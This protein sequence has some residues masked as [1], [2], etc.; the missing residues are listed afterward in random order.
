MASIILVADIDGPPGKIGRFSFSSEEDLNTLAENK[1]ALK[2]RDAIKF[3]RSVFT[4]F[5]D[6][7]K[8]IGTEATMC[9]ITAQY[10]CV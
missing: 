3:A 2:T 8:K 7:L 6:I 10:E 5:C 1:D 9:F 4:S